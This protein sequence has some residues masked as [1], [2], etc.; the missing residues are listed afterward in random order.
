M[1]G[2][3]EF[4]SFIPLELQ[5]TDGKIETVLYSKKHDLEINED[6]YNHFSQYLMAVFNTH[7]EEKKTDDPVLKSWYIRKD[8]RDLEIK[9]EKK[10]RNMPDDDSY[11]LADLISA[12]T[13]HPGFKY[14]LQ[15]LRD[16]HVYQFFDAVSRLQVYESTTA[17]MKGM[18]SGFVDTSKIPQSAYNF[19]RSIG[20]E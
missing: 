8:K 16:V 12:C 20:S 11:S 13:N 1:F 5:H 9:K 10:E 3:I 15:E 14:N 19:M 18:Y 4:E 6:V 2:N 17:L 7:P